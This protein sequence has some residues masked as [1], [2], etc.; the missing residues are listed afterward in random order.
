MR[1]FTA[2]GVLPPVIAVS[3]VGSLLSGMGTSRQTAYAFGNGFS[4]KDYLTGPAL[5][6]RLEW[7]VNVA[8]VE[9][10]FRSVLR[11]LS[12]GY[13]I[14]VLLDR[15]VDPDRPI[16]LQLRDVSLKVVLE[17]LAREGEAELL[18]VGPVAYI[19]PVGKAWQALAAAETCE[20]ILRLSAPTIAAE[21]RRPSPLSWPDFTVPRE[22]LAQLGQEIGWKVIGLERIPHDLWAGAEL[23]PLTVFEKL[24]LVGAQFDLR[25]IPEA[26]AKEIRLEP[27]EPTLQ[28]RRT[29][30]LS[31]AQ[32][33]A[34][35]ALRR[36]LPQA[37]VTTRGNQLVVFGTWAEHE[38]VM[39]WLSREDDRQPARP[40]RLPERRYTLR[41]AR[42]R[43]ETVFKQLSTALGLELR[44][45][46]EGLSRVGILP[47]TPVSFSA[48]NA[49]LEELLR[50]AT[51]SVGCD[52]RLEGNVLFVFPKR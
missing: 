22:L 5:R 47:D 4:A 46:Y 14:G 20:E 40:E 48:E 41:Q 36:D 9:R 35:Q 1:I 45:D 34:I 44:L 19:A 31:P 23:P 39:Q 18:W 37:E 2:P 51:D 30:S 50:A 25:P 12:T 11:S 15:R 26:Q 6:S 28:W 10:P 24:A 17:Q 21:W 8:F 13:Q 49:T 33:G 43:F 16:T 38:R 7:H 42:G 32:A 29:Y 52:Y 3:L 27:V